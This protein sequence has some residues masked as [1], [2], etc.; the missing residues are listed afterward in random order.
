[1]QTILG[2]GGAIGLAMAEILPEYT[3][4]VRLVSRNP[5]PVA[6]ENEIYPANLLNPDEAAGAVAGSEVVYLLA[7]LPYRAKVW[8][9]HWPRIMQNTIEACRTSGSKL[10]FFDNIYM[11]DRDCLSPMDENTPVRPTSRKGQVRADIADML[12]TATAQGDIQGLIARCA[13]FYGPG[14]Q[15]NSMLT[16]TVFDRLA[17]GKSAQWLLSADH[18]HSF[19][20]TL[21]AARGTA[22]LGNA[23]EV[24]GEVWHL[25]TASSPPTGR[26]WI[27]AI[28]SELG[29]RP[30]VQVVSKTLLGAISLFSPTMRDIREMAYQYDR[31]YDFVSAK[32]ERRFGFEPTPYREGIRAVVDA[33][34]R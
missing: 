16:Y 7:G 24:Y 23:D 11:Y 3:D 9:S 12:L 18:V 1:M 15:Q 33:D 21:D 20:Y 2:A 27:E 10:V 4:R 29:L 34:Y 6:P 14:R 8:E 19:T 26:G 5:R 28:A 25:P 31:D 32:F 13:D 30:K 17:A 22:M